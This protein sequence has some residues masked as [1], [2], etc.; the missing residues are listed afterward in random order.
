MEEM[1]SAN[2]IVVIGYSLPE[3]DVNA[4]SRILTAFQLNPKCHWLII[5]P[6][7]K[8]CDLYRKLLGCKNVTIVQTTLAAFNIEFLDNLKNV[9]PDI[10]YQDNN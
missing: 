10:D 2:Y 4:R 1:L 6:S 7:E 5:D 8:I 9:F 3:M